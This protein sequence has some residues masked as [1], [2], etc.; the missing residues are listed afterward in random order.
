MFVAIYF[1]VDFK[2]EMKIL[3]NLKD[4]NILE[5]FGCC[6]KTETPG[7]VLEYM[8]YGDLFQFLRDRILEDSVSDASGK[9][10]LR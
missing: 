7:I 5:V 3:S 6:T 2:K 10:C 9:R 4:P 1:R 8:I